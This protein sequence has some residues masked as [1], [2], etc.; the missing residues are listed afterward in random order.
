MKRPLHIAVVGLGH[1]GTVTAACLARSGHHVYGLDIDQERLAA[2]A[3]GRSPI[4]E[5]GVDELLRRGMAAGLVQAV[6]SVEPLIDLLDLALVCVGTPCGPAG[7]LD[8]GDLVEAIRNLARPARRRDGTRWPLVIAVRSTTAPGT[9][10]EVVV[11]ILVHE[12]GDDLGDRLE[13]AYNPAFLREGSA[14]DDFHNPPKIVIGERRKGAAR[15]LY[16]VYDGIEV[17]FRIGESIKLIDNAFHALKVAFANEVGRLAVRAGLDTRLLVELFLIDRTLNV[18]A[19]Y[20]RPGGPF[21]GPC[22]SKDLQELMGLARD[23]G[24]RLPVLDAVRESNAC[25]YE[26]LLEAVE[27]ACSPPGPILLIGLSFKEGT[28]DVRNSP[29]LALAD[30]LLRKGYHLD[31]LDPDFPPDVRGKKKISKDEPYQSI[32]RRP[33]VETVEAAPRR[34]QLIIVGKGIRDLATYLPGDVP[35]LDLS[36]FRFP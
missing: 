13:I 29:N 31:V 2:F 17:P 18:S 15:R 4:V 23:L 21:G 20:L 36:S 9:M 28:D 24:V 26:F 5:T 30:D 3:Q 32:M 7:R 33:T 34:P 8:Y 10:D 12:L 6:A 35:V 11:P 1:V 14:V 22:L 25:H 19:A 27:K 16:G